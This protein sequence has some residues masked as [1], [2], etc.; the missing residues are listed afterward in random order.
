MSR[1]NRRFTP[2]QKAQF[3]RRHLADK[4]LVS[5]LAEEFAALKKLFG[6]RPADCD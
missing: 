6:R 4:E 5:A 1:T 2:Q 3:V